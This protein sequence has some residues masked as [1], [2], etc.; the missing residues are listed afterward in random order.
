[1]NKTS[2]G[3]V[4]MLKLA[5]ALSAVQKELKP[6]LKNAENPH[7][8]SA[9]VDL[10]G[11]CAVV[12]PLLA[13]HGLAVSQVG[14]IVETRF[15]LITRLYLNDE[16]IESEWPVISDKQTAQAIGSAV[17]YARRYSL[18]AIVGASSTDDDDANEASTHTQKTPDVPIAARYAPPAYKEPVVV[19]KS[20][21]DQINELAKVKRVSND[22]L[23]KMIANYGKKKSTECSP[24]ELMAILAYLENK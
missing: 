15:V 2:K 23:K 5:A 21:I 17:S 22:D 8:R 24:D 4:C 1:M 6:I 14:K 3:G 11:V 10:A 20:L 9:Y 16:F 13:K 19:E 18:M 12:L 7:F